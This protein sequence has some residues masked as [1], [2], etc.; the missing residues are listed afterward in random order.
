MQRRMLPISVLV[1]VAALGC[2]RS[3]KSSKASTLPEASA[4]AA[5][6]EAVESKE[7]VPVPDTPPEELATKEMPVGEPLK[8]KSVNS[9]TQRLLEADEGE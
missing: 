7:S 1:F 8:F 5:T 2:D 9:K 3:S 4:A 6:G